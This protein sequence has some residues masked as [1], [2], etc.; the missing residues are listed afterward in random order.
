MIE[1]KCKNGYRCV[2]LNQYEAREL[3][4]GDTC[5]MCIHELQF[6]RFFVPV[7]GY[8]ICQSCL[9]TWEQ[10]EFF[11]EDVP[12]ENESLSR[13]KHLGLPYVVMEECNEDL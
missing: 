1:Q 2:E 13:L 6:T 3:G 4:W 9:E 11:E 12:Y 7:L 8:G 5:D 10:T